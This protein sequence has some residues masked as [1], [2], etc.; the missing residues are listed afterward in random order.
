MK[1][2]LLNPLWSFE[3]SIYFG[4]REPHLPIELGSCRVLL[5]AAGHE[6][7]M[8]DGALDDLD[9][10]AMADRVAAFAPDMTVITTAPTYLF[11][12]CAQ[13]EL[14][15]PRLLM[16]AI[17]ARGAATRLVAVGPHGSATP[18]AALRKTGADVLVR[19]ECE[20][21]VLALADGAE[22]GVLPGT[23]LLR[24][25]QLVAAGGPLATR[26]TDLPALSWP[27]HWVRR[28]RHH[29]HRYDQ[30]HEGSGHDLPGAEV[31]ASR[32]CPY[33]CSFCA[34]IDFR[35]KY[36]RRELAPLL[37]EIDALKAQGVGYLY[38]IDEIFLPNRE[39]LE[40]LV[41]RGLRFGVQTRID[42]WKPEM[43]ELLGRAG[44][45]SI[46]AGVES[47]TVEGRAALD[48]RCKLDTDQLADLLILA[49]Q[50]VPFVQANLI[51]MAGDDP[52]LV[53]AWREKLLAH[54]VWANDPVP[55]YPYPSSPDYRKLFGLPDDQAWERAHAHYL[56][57]FDSMSDIQDDT[58]RPLPEL[59]AVCTCP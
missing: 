43:I 30:P 57:L 50:H 42:L 26:F 1:V 54:G 5:E 49:K 31:E 29:H 17:R 8:L 16:D 36:R 24:D 7:L 53:T 40:A 3:G 13:P 47:L 14:R 41:P 12:R 32:G 35:D 51:E 11:W 46:E 22:P 19:G 20:E 59:E 18:D 34:K 37:A 44:C 55:L 15:I 2:A 52:A 10:P 38:F 4:C 58:P 27:D 33:T 21:A 25:G 6:T 23:A 56:G 48:K 9:I 39:L 28:H 45:V